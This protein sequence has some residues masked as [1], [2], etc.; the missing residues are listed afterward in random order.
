MFPSASEVVTILG[1]ASKPGPYAQLLKVGAISQIGLATI[2]YARLA[3]FAARKMG[4][5]AAQAS[6]DNHNKCI[7]AASLSARLKEA[8]IRRKDS[9]C[10]MSSQPVYS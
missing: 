7:I 3:R 1:D 2:V 5:K 6:S 8:A 10:C 9:M 4:L